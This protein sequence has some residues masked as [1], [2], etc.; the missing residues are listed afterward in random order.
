MPSTPQLNHDV[1]CA[2]AYAA[3]RRTCASIMLT[4]K[5]L[6]HAAAK[7]V[8]QPLFGGNYLWKEVDVTKFLRFLRADPSR[9]SYVRQLHI[10][11]TR[12]PSEV[13]EQLLEGL[14]QMT[15]LVILGLPNG[16]ATLE[17]FPTLFDALSKMTMI[18][19]LEVRF[20]GLATCRLLWNMQARL[21]SI[22]LDWH[23]YGNDFF[24]HHLPSSGSTHWADYHPVPLLSNWS[25]TLE[26]LTCVYWITSP[27]GL[28]PFTQT[29]P[30]LRRLFVESEANPHVATYIR[31]YP[32]LVQLSVLSDDNDVYD[33]TTDAHAV[34]RAHERRA[35]NIRSQEDAVGDGRGT[36]PHLEAFIGGLIDLY[37]LG[38]TCRILRVSLCFSV[39]PRDLDLL[40]PVLAY[41]QPQHLKVHGTGMLLAHPRYGLTK[42]LRE[43]CAAR[44][45]S[46]VLGL[47][48]KETEGLD[49]VTTLNDLADSLKRI[50]LRRLRLCVNGTNFNLP[51]PRPDPYNPRARL[52]TES[53]PPLRP[54]ATP[55]TTLEKA[56]WSVDI[57]AYV[58]GLADAI[59]SLDDA[60]MCIMGEPDNTFDYR[61]RSAEVVRVRRAEYADRNVYEWSSYW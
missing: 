55:T 41:A 12:L 38:I 19:R 33:H 6:K 11:F 35:V 9:F 30:K 36:W 8:L 17:E 34:Q 42:L 28:P 7:S 58:Q 21:T 37:L 39:N 15:Q 13:L 5:S 49:V 57:D 20:A 31:A 56:L 27:T 1:L 24:H 18:R 51:I 54:I 46:L 2:I 45:E 50:P 52:R 22:M 47:D 53:L 40:P 48:F 23:P 44:L 59:P 26:E 32:N 29:Y 4:S 61:T 60:I 10:G 25:A 3:D 43:H 14:S 16:D